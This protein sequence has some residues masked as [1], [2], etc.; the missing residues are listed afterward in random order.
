M[1]AR[2]LYHHR[3]RAFDGQA[4]HILEMLGALLRAGADVREVAL[5]KHAAPG[6][7]GNRSTS[8]LRKLSLP[9]MAVEVLERLYSRTGRKLLLGAARQLQPDLIYERHALH[10]RAGM[11]AA[12]GLGLP[13]FLEVNSPM[14]DEM[15]QL[16]LLR[17]P[18]LARR[19]E[20]EVFAAADRVFV[21]TQVLAEMVEGLGAHAE[22]I[23]VMPNGADLAAF[24][25]VG[26]VDPRRQILAPFGWPE[27]AF[28]LGFVGFPRPWHRLDLALA[29]VAAQPEA[30][31]PCLLVIGDGPAV[32]D[33]R[34]QA[35]RL[36]LQQRFA[37]TGAVA[38]KDI[39]HWVASLN[40]AIIPAMNAYASPLKL[41]DSLAAGV[42]TLAPDQP[43]LR[44]TVTD[45]EHALLF[46]PDSVEA[47]SGRLGDLLADAPEAAR[48]GA[49]GRAHLNDLDLT[50]DANARR[51]LRELDEVRR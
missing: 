13:F 34:M 25:A 46:T 47:V 48:I 1:S 2:I 5:V 39:P 27:D 29:A 45:G 22:R 35:E 51:V 19:T 11:L 31:R 30:R 32:D 4:V 28:V 21:V 36:G 38:R 37:V 7:L 23:V 12:R 9:R 42:P 49:A 16:G 43:N 41:Y 8:L 10:C 3:T 44:E 40:A 50:W 24:D 14:V 6:A 15:Q 17:F 33:L 20:R 18:A 26:G